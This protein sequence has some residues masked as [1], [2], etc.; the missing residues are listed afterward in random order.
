MDK[1]I[2]Q[3]VCLKFCVANEISYAESL[4]MFEKAHGES[5]L[6]KTRAY[7]WYKA[8]KEGQEEVEDLF[9]SGQLLTSSSDE[10]IDKVKW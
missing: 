5:A 6:S 8:F 10:N 1:N 2:E 3:K 4:K 7:E 9:P